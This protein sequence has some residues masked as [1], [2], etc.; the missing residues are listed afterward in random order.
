LDDFSTSTGE[1]KDILYDSIKLASHEESVNLSSISPNNYKH[2]PTL[3]KNINIDKTI[4]K[5]YYIV[6]EMCMNYNLF[7][8]NMS[9]IINYS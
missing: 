1:L 4:L 3:S 8:T 5:C 9:F 7:Y 2:S 6:I